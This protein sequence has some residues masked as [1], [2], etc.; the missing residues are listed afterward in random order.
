MSCEHGSIWFARNCE[1]VAQWL[2]RPQV[3]IEAA[4]R[5]GQS[6]HI[7]EQSHILAKRLDDDG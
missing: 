2:E 5:R 7:A 4:A 6:L 1:H 3:E